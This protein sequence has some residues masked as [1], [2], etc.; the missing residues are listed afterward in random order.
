LE[1]PTG[2]TWQGDNLYVTDS[3][4]NSIHQ[5]TVSSDRTTITHTGNKLAL[6]FNSR[7]ITMSSDGKQLVIGNTPNLSL[8]VYFLT[9]PFDIT[10]ATYAGSISL[11]NIIPSADRSQTLLPN[12]L[13]I[14]N[15]TFQNLTFNCQNNDR[16]YY[17]TFDK[18]HIEM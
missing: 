7:G 5:L 15:I 9:T 13:H 1:K 12:A 6:G 10:T 18:E 3:F 16:A 17:L 8:N 2:I 4:D 11:N 14:D